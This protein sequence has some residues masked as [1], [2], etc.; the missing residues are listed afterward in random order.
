MG[1][2]GKV[3]W[4]SYKMQNGVIAVGEGKFTL[5]IRN[6]KRRSLRLFAF[7][8]LHRNW[9]SF[10]KVSSDMISGSLIS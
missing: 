4:A 10:L 7:E 9:M 3:K 5:V 2:S 8:S 1:Q 6:I